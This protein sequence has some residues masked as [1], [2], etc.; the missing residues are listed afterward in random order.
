MIF[1]ERIYDKIW[2][3]VSVEGEKLHLE[4]PVMAQV[5]LDSN[6]AW[7]LKLHYTPYHMNHGAFVKTDQGK[8]FMHDTR[9]H[10]SHLNQHCY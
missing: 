6:I 4:Y 5:V 3:L 9:R 10:K 2:T 8:I 1:D 7:L